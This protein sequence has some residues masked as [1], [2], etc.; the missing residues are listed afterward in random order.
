MLSIGRIASLH[1]HLHLHK[2]IPYLYRQYK[3][4]SDNRLF[5]LDAYALIFRAYYAF[6]KN[7]RITSYGL[8]TSAIFGFTNTLLDLLE[9]QK[10]SH[11]AVVFDHKS[12]TF[13]EQEHSF[14]KANRDETPEDI[15]KSEPYIRKIIE[16]FH[17]P[18]LEAPGYEADDVI[19]T[20]AHRGEEHGFTTFMM[21][22]DKDFGQL[23]TD[24]I[25]M[26]RPGRQ[27]SS[28]EIW[29]PDEVCEKFGLDNPLQVIDYLGLMGDS[30]DNIPGVPGVGPKTASKLIKDFGSMEDIYENLDQL[31]GKLKENMENNKEQAFISKKLATILTDAPVTFDVEN[32]VLDEPDKD[33]LNEIFGELEFRTLGKRVLGQDPTLLPN[34]GQH[35]L[36]G[37]MQGSAPTATEAVAGAAEETGIRTIENTEHSY[38]LVNSKKDRQNLLKDLLKQKSVCF[39][40]ETTDLDP[41]D[42][43]IL[44]CAFS[45]EEGT[46]YYVAIEKD[47]DKA[48]EILS[49]FAEF[50]EHTGIEKILQNA[51]YD[52]RILWN[53]DIK[54][55]GPIFDTMLA[56][57]LV[58]PDQRHNMDDLSEKYLS[59]RPISITS[60]I[61]KKGKNQLS[62][63]TVD[64][65]KATEYASEDADITY[66]LKQKLEPLL[67]DKV[68]KVFDDIEIPLVP[69]LARMENEG[70]RVD[71]DF[72]ANYSKE[73][74]AEAVQIEKDIIDAAEGAK[75]NIASPKQLGE[76]LFDHL[77]LDS[78]AKKTRTG[79]YK[80]DEET[81]RKLAD[82]HPLPKLVLDY[83]QIQK[84]RSTYVD[85]IPTL[86][87][88]KTGRVHTSFGQAIAA[89]GRLSSQHPNL[90]NIPIRT[91]KG[92]EIRKAFVARD[93]NSVLL[94][95]D[96]SQIELRI[97][98]SVAEDEAMMEA[99]NN[100]IDIHRATAAKVFQVDLDDVTDDMRRQAKTVNFGIIYGISAF[101]LSQRAGISRVE[102]KDIID[103]YFEQFSGIKRY[104]DSTIAFAREHGYVETLMGRRRNIRDIN[105]Q[106]RTVVGF[107][108]RNAINAPIQGTAA[109]MIKLAMIHIDKALQ[110]S[111][112]KSK[113]ILQVHDELLF[114]VPKEELDELRG[115]IVPLMENAMPLKVPLKVEAGSGNNWLE[116][117]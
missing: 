104:M 10:P 95:A 80:T 47:H 18:I 103:S 22:S 117:H 92:R 30:V 40:T 88:P 111:K 38:T 96:Y 106:N 83:R 50:F 49:E 31:K 86:I 98:A 21:T 7:P 68:R 15:K 11:V 5:L 12:P 23:V 32:L 69:V 33:K 9:K 63:D 73:L 72:L 107:A 81:L 66:Q 26:Y 102:A 34:G 79:Q 82:K 71:A 91:D 52:I 20:L 77:K 59:Y 17:I 89:T 62:F 99:F 6:I 44:G 58:E 74:E 43:D 108:E 46:G 90:Q 55:K 78:K 51:K 48:K 61:G 85:A 53:Y 57:Y 2:I 3:N 101:G 84:L 14:Y 113:M 54:V 93:E 41:L 19:G 110:E 37:D 109:D 75:F 60:L 115:M 94:A 100:G 70:V 35:S 112:L 105:S 116:A 28:V 24:K 42:A 45:W 27:G 97:V 16:A 29:G 65:D 87:N 25:K 56:H 36:F 76:V 1:L 4:M 67:Q 39:D 64:L 114:D 13:R 8:N